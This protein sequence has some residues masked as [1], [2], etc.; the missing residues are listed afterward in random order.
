M[1]SANTG[2]VNL[3]TAMGGRQAA[4]DAINAAKRAAGDTSSDVTL[5]QLNG[6]VY[7]GMVPQLARFYLLVGAAHVGIDRKRAMLL[8]DDLKAT[9]RL[10]DAIAAQRK[11]SVAA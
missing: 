2:L 10:A 5:R 8:W 3:L 6:W 4:V 9:A 1:P 7:A 11:P